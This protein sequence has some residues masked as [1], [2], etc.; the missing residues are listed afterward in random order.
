MKPLIVICCSFLAFLAIDLAVFLL[1]GG[2]SAHGS[3][4]S[5]IIV[6]QAINSI[7]FGGCAFIWRNV[8]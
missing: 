6:M 1:T 7:L 8:K 5:E 3:L 2:I 4:P